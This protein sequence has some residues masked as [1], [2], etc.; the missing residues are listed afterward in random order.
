[1]NVRVLQ[2][3]SR[4]KNA[5]ALLELELFPLGPPLYVLILHLPPDAHGRPG[6][7]TRTES[8]LG[9][10]LELYDRAVADHVSVAAAE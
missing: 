10:A 2:T 3:A 6:H 5:V 4:Q 1:M 9:D 8:E 7:W